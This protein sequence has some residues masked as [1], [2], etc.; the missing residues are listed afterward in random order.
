MPESLL[1]LLLVASFSDLCRVLEER[2]KKLNLPLEVQQAVKLGKIELHL[3]LQCMLIVN[4]LFS[5]CT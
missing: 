5:L 3:R 4:L 1:K 2:S